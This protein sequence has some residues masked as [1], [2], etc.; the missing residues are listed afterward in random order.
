MSSMS[1]NWPPLLMVAMTAALAW[2]RARPA[3]VRAARCAAAT[4]LASW[5]LRVLTGP[6]TTTTPPMPLRWC[7]PGLVLTVVLGPP[8]GQ[9]AE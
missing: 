6:A 3:L 9:G 1:P 8:L 5:S 4:C 2:R 7:A